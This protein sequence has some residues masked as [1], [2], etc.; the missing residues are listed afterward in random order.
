MIVLEGNKVK[1]TYPQNGADPE[2]TFRRKRD[3]NYK[4]YVGN[5]VE[6]RD[7]EKDVSIIIHHDI[8]QNIHSDV[9]FAQEVLDDEEVI[10]RTETICVDGCYY[11][12]KVIKK[13]EEKNVNINFSSMTGTRPENEELL[14]HISTRL[15]MG[16]VY[17]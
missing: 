11:S 17:V 16:N 5:V 8:Q 13:A 4:G 3:K 14:G 15:R 1:S 7:K 9:A 10:K 12:S 6:A 2:S